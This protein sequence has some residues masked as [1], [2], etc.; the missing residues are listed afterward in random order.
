MSAAIAP[1]LVVVVVLALDL[2]VY[3]DVKRCAEQG[4][5]VVF[6]IGTLVVDTPAKCG[7]QAA[8]FCGS[9]PSRSTW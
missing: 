2:W 9:S 6:Q 1:L 4:E 8:W 3:A 5:P 7:S